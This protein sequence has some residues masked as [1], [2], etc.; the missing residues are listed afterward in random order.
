VACRARHGSPMRL[1]AVL[2]FEEGNEG[3][4]PRGRTVAPTC[5]ALRRFPA[6]RCT[7][8]RLATNPPEDD[9]QDRYDHIPYPYGEFAGRAKEI[10]RE[11]VDF[12]VQSKGFVI[13]VPARGVVNEQGGG[14]GVGHPSFSC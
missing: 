12:C 11:L 13:G 1:G 5:H 14:P 10:V 7:S 9:W 6:R 2:L 4:R 8:G 3:R